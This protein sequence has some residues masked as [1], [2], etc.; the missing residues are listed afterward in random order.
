MSQGVFDGQDVTE[1][2]CPVCGVASWE[3]APTCRS[4]GTTLR[5]VT[6][7]SPESLWSTAE[8]SLFDE[9]SDADVVGG[10][11]SGSAEGGESLWEDAAATGGTV[12]AAASASP[13]FA[14]PA[15]SLPVDDVGTDLWEP[16]DDG[17]AAPDVPLPLDGADPQG[18][19]AA[20]GRLDP[21]D[22]ERAVVPL[23]VCSVL[24]EDDE[25]VTAALVGDMLGQPAAMVLTGRRVLVANGRRWRP[26]VDSFPFGPGLG[27]RGRHDGG[28]AAVTLL[29]DE[30]LVTVDG[31]AD[32][33]AA[34]RFADLVRARSGA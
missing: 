30:R 1:V 20:V 8:D 17:G 12:A 15:A 25:V 34:T 27:V 29:D 5:P 16:V 14:A 3:G 4:C 32:V 9:V 10:P 19:G 24:L 28:V 2:E 6:A 7:A 22:V 23:A 31:V 33:P 18:L 21:A 13:L 11:V 26:V